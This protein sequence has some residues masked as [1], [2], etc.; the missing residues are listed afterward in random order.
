MKFI[1][2]H[3]VRKTDGMYVMVIRFHGMKYSGC[4]YISGKGKYNEESNGDHRFL[5]W[6]LSNQS[7]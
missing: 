7:G 3:L 6:I 5:V 4:M 1:Y 2:A